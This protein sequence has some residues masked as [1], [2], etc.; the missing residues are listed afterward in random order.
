MPVGT[1]GHH[2]EG[3]VAGTGTRR[4]ARSRWRG[5]SILPTLPT[6]SRCSPQG[7]CATTRRCARPREHGNGGCRSATRPR[8]PARGRGKARPR[9]AAAQEQLPAHRRGAVRQRDPTHDHRHTAA[10]ATGVR[11]SSQGRTRSAAQAERRRST[12]ARPGEPP[13]TRPTTC[14]Q[15]SGCWPSTTTELPTTRRA[16]RSTAC[17]GLIAILD[18]P[19][20]R[21]STI[22]ALPTRRHHPG[23]HHRRPPRHRHRDRHTNRH[24]RGHD[25]AARDDVVATGPQIARGEVA[26]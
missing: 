26:T 12:T 9:A 22:A 18:P 2:V 14:R 17:C 13:A 16:S 15:G 21:R 23:P 3:A 10:G 19:A 6:W 24:H 7:C 20:G 4:T 25:E 8:G 5:T 11:S 1:C